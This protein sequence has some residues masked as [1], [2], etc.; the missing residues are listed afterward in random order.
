M[1]DFAELMKPNILSAIMWI[2][3]SQNIRIPNIIHRSPLLY[4][5]ASFVL[6]AL[7]IQTPNI[8]Q[9]LCKSTWTQCSYCAVVC[10]CMAKTDTSHNMIE[11]IKIVYETGDTPS[12]NALWFSVS[13]AAVACGTRPLSASFW[14][15][16][17]N[18][19]HDDLRKCIT[20]PWIRNQRNVN[21]QK[22]Q[23]HILNENWE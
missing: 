11:L 14:V 20:Q 7:V 19:N 5:D 21:I 2:R 1:S 17:R 18:R 8:S 4:G 23:M 6:R 15:H 3:R 16:F 10:L 22:R 9:V 13:F 12:L